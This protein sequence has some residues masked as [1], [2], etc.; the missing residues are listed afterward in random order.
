MMDRD[1]KADRIAAALRKIADD[2]QEE[3]RYT[4]GST[5]ANRIRAMAALVLMNKPSKVLG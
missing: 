4:G 2:I 1:A 5:H 3:Y